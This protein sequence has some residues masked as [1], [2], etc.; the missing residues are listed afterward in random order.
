M[1]RAVDRLAALARGPHLP[2]ECEEDLLR[3]LRTWVG[4]LQDIGELYWGVVPSLQVGSGGPLVAAA[5]P[6]VPE[7][8]AT[9][10]GSAPAPPAAPPKAAHCPPPRPPAP[11]VPAA[12][13]PDAGEDRAGPSSSSR[14]HVPKKKRKSRTPE[15]N[16]RELHHVGS[17]PV[18]NGL[19][20]VSENEVVNIQVTQVD[21][22]FG[23]NQ[24]AASNLSRLHQYSAHY[25]RLLIIWM[26][27][28]WPC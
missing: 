9:S 3:S 17:Q 4:N 14:L 18:L 26:A 13:N 24:S 16:Q 21:H 23:P 8:G 27:L 6:P 7:E 10:K 11:E 2:K 12:R 20:S 1:C 19:F 5:P 22:E 15:R 25:S 28:R